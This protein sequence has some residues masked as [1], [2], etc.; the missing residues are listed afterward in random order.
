M[1]ACMHAHTHAHIFPVENPCVRILLR[2][3]RSWTN[4]NIRTN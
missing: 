3:P 1:H 4:D 2:R